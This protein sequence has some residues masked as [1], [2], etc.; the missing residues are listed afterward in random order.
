MH[1]PISYYY[2]PLLWLVMAST[3]VIKIS[4]TFLF[5]FSLFHFSLFA[6]DF[7]N[8][9]N[10]YYGNKI[11]YFRIFGERCSGTNFIT[12]LVEANCNEINDFA[13]FG[14]KHFPYWFDFPI[15]PSIMKAIGYPHDNDSLERS[16]DCLFIIILRDPYDW[17]CS[18]FGDPHEVTD[19][20][21]N[22]GFSCFIRSIWKSSSDVCGLIDDYNPYTKAPFKN[23][24]ELRK[25]KTIN[26]L[27]MGKNVKNF[28]LVRY[29]DLENDPKGFLEHLSRKY[30]LS[31]AQVFCPIDTYK[32]EG[33]P[34]VKKQ[35]PLIE[36]HDL[37]FINEN[38]DWELESQ[39]GYQQYDDPKRIQAR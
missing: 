38:L 25:Y 2:Q 5:I 20:I 27:S 4:A 6:I 36:P 3:R 24:L 9:Y 13:L 18:F 16:G 15:N 22:H 17:L 28:C 14:H 21:K 31:L 8:S 7:D 39:F 23:V 30:N 29:E 10:H 1:P 33:N 12:H 37:H 26:Y 32:G 19:E 34:Y 11:K 35:Y